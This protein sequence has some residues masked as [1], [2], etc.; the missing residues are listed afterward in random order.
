MGGLDESSKDE[1]SKLE[2]SCVTDQADFKG[3]QQASA[4]ALV[5]VKEDNEV[6]QNNAEEDAEQQQCATEN[7]KRTKP[8]SEQLILDKQVSADKL[9]SSQKNR[10]NT[11]DNSFGGKLQYTNSRS[12]SIHNIEALG[13]NKAKGES[14]KNAYDLLASQEQK[15]KEPEFKFNEQELF[16]ADSS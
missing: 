4:A 15:L 11:E 16:E 13:L 8:D 9:F 5:P 6:V 3:T 10:A 14:L 7:E 2:I 1:A 12:R